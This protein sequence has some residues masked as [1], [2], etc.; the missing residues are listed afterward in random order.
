M[1]CFSNTDD[2]LIKKCRSDKEFCEI[3]LKSMELG[4]EGIYEEIEIDFE[5]S[6]LSK[7]ETN[8]NKPENRKVV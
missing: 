4:I 7:F 6:K 2:F 1:I 5:L 8:T 3:L